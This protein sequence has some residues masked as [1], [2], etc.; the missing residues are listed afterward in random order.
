MAS[1]HLV[2][3]GTSYSASGPLSPTLHQG[4]GAKGTPRSNRD[5]LSRCADKLPIQTRSASSNENEFASRTQAL[6]TVPEEAATVWSPP[7]VRT[8]QSCGHHTESGGCQ[9]HGG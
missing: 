1:P 2:R 7:D 9:A 5:A 4:Q 8:G 6:P 3:R